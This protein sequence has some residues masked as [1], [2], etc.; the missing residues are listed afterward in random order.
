MPRSTRAYR[1]LPRDVQRALRRL[2]RHGLGALDES[3]VGD[4]L[5]IARDGRLRPKVRG[6]LAIDNFGNL[7]LRTGPGFEQ[8]P[9]SPVRLQAK[10]S[11]PIELDGSGRMGLSPDTIL[12]LL[13]EP[14]L[15]GDL[16]TWQSG[17]LRPYREGTVGQ[18][19]RKQADGTW[20]A[21]ALPAVVTDHGG[22]TGL[23]DDDHPQYAPHLV[24]PIHALGHSSATWAVQPAAETFLFDND[25]HVGLF[26]LSLYNQARLVVKME[27]TAAFA[28]ATLALRFATSFSGTVGDYANIGDPDALTV[29]I[30]SADTV[31]ASAWEDMDTDAQ[32][33]VFLAVVGAGGNGVV[34]PA[35][36]NIW[37]QFRRAA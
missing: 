2:K 35:F 20:K 18:A 4:A 7:V 34:S 5:E 31:V 16:F 14:P 3:G 27:G 23:E 24:V 29:A 25:R 17:H 15:E 6:A 21:Q 32:A 10:L 12:R 36:G 22:L 19:I 13:P 37:A 26:D 33:D 30:D 11:S 9:G 8:V 28:G 1:T